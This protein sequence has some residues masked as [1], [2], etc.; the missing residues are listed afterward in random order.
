MFRTFSNF[1]RSRLEGF[2]GA[3]VDGLERKGAPDL[4]LLPEGRG[5][6]LVEFGSDA[7]GEADAMARRLI[8]RLKQAADPPDIRLYTKS[9]ARAVWKIRES[10]PRAAGSAPGSP[11]RWEGWDDASVAPEK[12]GAYLRDLRRL[13]DEY[14][15]QAAYYGH[16]GHGC[17][18]MQVTFDLVTENGIRRY[19]DFVDRAADLVVGYGGSISG[20]HGDGQSRGA[21]L[22]KMFGTELMTAFREFKS[23]WD[24]DNKLNPHKLVDAYLPTE[25]LRLGADY[26]PLQPE[27]HFKFPD[28]GGSFAKASLRCIGLGECRKHD[29]GTMCPSYRVTLEEEHSTRGR[30]HLLFEL[31]QGEIVRNRW[32]DEQVKRALDLCLSCKACK[33]ECPTNV[34]IATY[35]AEF[36]SHYYESRPRPLN[37]YVF[38][39]IDRWSRLASFAPGMANVFSRSPGLGRLLKRILHVAPERRLPRFAPVSFLQ[40]ARKH[41]VPAFGHGNDRERASSNAGRN[42]VILWVDTFNNYFHPETLRAA[43][44]LLR[45]AG[46]T[47]TIPAAP[48]VLRPAAVRLRLDRPGGEIPAARPA[49]GRRTD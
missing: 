19:G 12:L 31:L 25:N 21:L 11:P 37:A 15:Y 26:R 34:D 48:T 7:A 17:I 4:E 41:R 6:L 1:S 45:T 3:I 38:G 16:F 40:W 46:F 9:E 2:E 5:F 18:H 30:A 10:G 29:S 22:P 24:P 43:L 49:R 28:D 13:L 8:D 14:G 36:L 20:E 44:E 42:A 33:S 23:I 32:K 27:T 47:V 39:M 35:R